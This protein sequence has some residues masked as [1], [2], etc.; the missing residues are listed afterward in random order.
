MLDS[1]FIFFPQRRIDETPADVGLDYED[2]YLTTSD[3]VR[4]HAWYVP[5]K[6]ERTLLLLHGNA[7]NIGHRVYNVMMTVNQLGVDVLIPDYRGYGR[8]E[9]TPT[10]QGTYLDGEA[11]LSYLTVE[12]GIEPT[13]LVL[14]GRSLGSAVA[15]ELA[16]RHSFHAVVLESPLTSVEEFARLHYPALSG[17]AAT[18]AAVRTQYDSL[19]KIGRVTSPLMILHGDVDDIVPFEMG[20]RLFAAAGEPKHFYRIEGAGHN[21]TYVVGGEAYFAALD[22]FIR[23]PG[24]E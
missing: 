10:E 23:N 15:V 7:G 3:G 9:G 21:D 8:S 1:Q 24:G 16:T 4:L 5:G 2:V 20:E 19:S 14:F 12:R 22:D 13:D 18:D 11:A 6:G 17:V